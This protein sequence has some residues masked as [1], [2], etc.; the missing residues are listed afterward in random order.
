[1]QINAISPAYSSNLLQKGIKQKKNVYSKNELRSINNS[2][3]SFKGGYPN[4]IGHIISEEPL[5]GISGGGVGTVSQDYNLLCDGFDK[6]IKYLLTNMFSTYK[7]NNSYYFYHLK[8]ILD[9]IILLMKFRFITL[10]N[11]W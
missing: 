9:N 2:V 4:Q 5:F 3:L 7:H 10:K 11:L 6:V 1:M 8:Q